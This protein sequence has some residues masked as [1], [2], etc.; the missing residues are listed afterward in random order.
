[1]HINERGTMQ[2]AGPAKT[3]PGRSALSPQRRR[4]LGRA[5]TLGR[6]QSQGPLPS[7]PGV[8][9]GFKQETR[10]FA[11][12]CTKPRTARVLPDYQTRDF[13]ARL[14]AQAGEPSCDHTLDAFCVLM[15]CCHLRKSLSN[16]DI[17]SYFFPFLITCIHCYRSEKPVPQLL[18]ISG[19]LLFHYFHLLWEITFRDSL[20]GKTYVVV[21]K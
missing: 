5:G 11:P 8:L 19:T 20:L 3:R 13:T 17:P 9:L 7:G 1:M 18:P 15:I 14:A 21:Y 16:T 4:A 6:R 2:H 12:G 10:I